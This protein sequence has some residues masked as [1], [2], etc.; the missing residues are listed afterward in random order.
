MH[1]LL[2]WKQIVEQ[3]K[4]TLKFQYIFWNYSSKNL[5]VYT[6]QFYFFLFYFSIHKCENFFLKNR[7]R[8]DLPDPE[9]DCLERNVRDLIHF[10]C[11][12]EV[13]LGFMKYCK[14][15]TDQLNAIIEGFLYH[16]S[17]SLICKNIHMCPFVKDKQDYHC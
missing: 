11:E 9:W 6:H 17:T 15:L 1:T 2:T 8:G 14:P 3:G 7:R 10:I 16:D 4:I 13:S 5:K 12:Q